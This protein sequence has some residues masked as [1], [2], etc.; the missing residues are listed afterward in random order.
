[1]T[2]AWFGSSLSLGYVRIA[3]GNRIKLAWPKENGLFYFGLSVQMGIIF[4]VVPFYL[5]INVYGILKDRQPC[6]T[7]CL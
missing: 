7:Y 3:S 5:L 4:G 6:V 1:M 2:V